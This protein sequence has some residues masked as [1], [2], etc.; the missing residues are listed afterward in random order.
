L[1]YIKDEMLE[2]GA[3]GVVFVPILSSIEDIRSGKSPIYCEST[4]DEW[5]AGDGNYLKTD[6]KYYKIIGGNRL[7][8]DRNLK[9]YR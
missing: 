8:Y 3:D 2:I 9:E 5:C 4:F 1:D 7:Y 6:R